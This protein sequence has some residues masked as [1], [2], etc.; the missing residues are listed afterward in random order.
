MLETYLVSFGVAVMPI[1]VADWEVVQ[2]LTPGGILGGAAAMALIDDDQVEEV[3]RE[4]AEQLLPL[5]GTSD[6]L[7]EPEVDL[8]RGIDPSLLVER[9]GQVNLGAVLAFDGL[10]AC[11]EL[12]H[13]GA[14]GPEVVDHRL[15]DEDVAVGEEQDAFLAAGLP[16]AAR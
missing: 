13:R 11:A 12:G 10:G 4:L 7:V 9:R 14:E 2:N 6:G 8:V 1:C 16:Q 5:L 15:I 3:R